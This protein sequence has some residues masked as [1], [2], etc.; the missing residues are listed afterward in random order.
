MSWLS[1][2]CQLGYFKTWIGVI[3][4]INLC[5]YPHGESPW[6][7]HSTSISIFYFAWGK[8]AASWIGKLFHSFSPFRNLWSGDVKSLIC[9]DLHLSLRPSHPPDLLPCNFLFINLTSRV[10]QGA[11]VLTIDNFDFWNNIQNFRDFPSAGQQYFNFRNG[12]GVG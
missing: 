10:C 4:I 11:P 8:L 9:P 12:V 3:N 1:L 7:S 5:V 6:I 2:T